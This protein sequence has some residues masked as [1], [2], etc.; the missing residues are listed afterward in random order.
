MKNIAT[1]FL[2]FALIL[3]GFVCAEEDVSSEIVY[4]QGDISVDAGVD[5]VTKYFFRGLLVEDDNYIVQPYATIYFHVVSG[6]DIEVSL[7]GGAWASL[8]GEDVRDAPGNADIE[9]PEVVNEV[10]V[11]AGVEI[12][13]YDILT[14]QAKYTVFTFPNSSGAAEDIH[15][16]SVIVSIDDTALTGLSF[17]LNPWM[18]Y[19]YEVHDSNPNNLN[20][21]D[22][23]A[24]FLIGVKPSVSI[25][26]TKDAVM[27]LSLPVTVGLAGNN[28]AYVDNNNNGHTYGFT[29]VGV[30]ASLPLFFIP[31][32]F[33]SW[34]FVAGLD[35]YFLGEAA[36]DA[37]FEGDNDNTAI[38][39]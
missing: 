7:F 3:S 1:L 19:A 12:S 2:I 14:V 11:Y 22:E 13:F 15:E 36:E 4:N 6:C 23:S 20:I 30:E 29:S 38:V 26:V 25:N 32:R 8:H 31:K 33:G 39:G 37:N 34:T 17:G 5:Y 28:N 9:D 35:A 21:N 27:T 16:V 10:D 24:Y 18:E